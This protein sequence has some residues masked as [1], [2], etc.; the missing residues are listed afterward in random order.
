LCGDAGDP[1]EWIYQ[2]HNPLP[3]WGKEGYG[4]EEWAQDKQFKLYADGRFYNIEEDDLET[5]VIEIEREEEEEAYRTLK[6]VLSHYKKQQ[7]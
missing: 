4:L 1:R 5:S 6:S 2:W 7:G 3:G